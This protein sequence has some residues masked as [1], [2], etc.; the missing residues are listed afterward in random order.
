MH[1]LHFVGSQCGDRQLLRHAFSLLQ[2]TPSQPLSSKRE[3]H[4]CAVVDC[5][6]L[7]TSACFTTDRRSLTAARS[8]LLTQGM[9][10]FAAFKPSSVSL[11]DCSSNG[12]IELLDGPASGGS[13]GRLVFFFFS[14]VLPW[15]LV[16][17]L[18]WLLVEP[19]TMR[20]DR[21]PPCDCPSPFVHRYRGGVWSKA[22]Y[23]SWLAQK[24]GD[25][26]RL[27]PSWPYNA[28][29]EL[30]VDAPHEAG[31]RLSIS[32]LQVVVVTASQ[33]HRERDDAVM[34][35]WG[36]MIPAGHLYMYSDGPDDEQRLPIIHFPHTP[37]RPNVSEQIPGSD[38]PR[39][40]HPHAQYYSLSG[41][42]Q[43]SSYQRVQIRWLQAMQHAMPLVLADP[44]I[45][46]LMFAD[47]D[48][49]VYWPHLLRL[50][51]DYSSSDKHTLANVL[52][53]ST[54]PAHVAG[55]A[56]W[57]LSRAVVETMVDR[58]AECYDYYWK[59]EGEDPSDIYYDV[60]V[61][62][63]FRDKLQL[64]PTHRWELEER[65]LVEYTY[66][67]GPPYPDYGHSPSLIF[68]RRNGLIRGATFHYTK[69][70]TLLALHNVAMAIGGR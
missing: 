53:N 14:T 5:A 17:S 9:S 25:D 62:R 38:P 44:S 61:S 48:T 21:L 37:G 47:D 57:L 40:T 42:D 49:F 13:I 32:Q 26:P 22:Q 6:A 39:Y 31:G 43:L 19:G 34:A 4:C 10:S 30:S 58:V 60:Q 24:P 20:S 63:C 16:L 54:H 67:P 1:N 29:Y 36:H 45:R 46:W 2:R 41:G 23:D 56:G 51:A 11:S 28:D 18:G 15:G 64:E 27:S 68:Q 69:A 59:N 35:S 7:H 66:P 3:L 12:H 50:C 65:P 33:A 52:I 70:E 8:L 55:G